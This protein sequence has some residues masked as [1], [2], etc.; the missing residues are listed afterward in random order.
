MNKAE[1]LLNCSITYRNSEKRNDSVP[2]TFDSEYQ[3]KQVMLDILMHEAKESFD[4][5]II[6][7][8]S[9][10][11][12]P[13][14]LQSATPGIY[15]QEKEVI[16]KSAPFP[17]IIYTLS[18]SNTSSSK[19]ETEK[20]VQPT[21][22]VEKKPRKY[23]KSLEEAHVKNN[24][25]TE[26]KLKMEEKRALREIEKEEEKEERKRLLEEETPEQRDQ[27]LNEQREKR[28]QKKQEKLEKE[29][30]ETAPKKE[31]VKKKNEIPED[32]EAACDQVLPPPPKKLSSKTEY[33]ECPI[34]HDRHMYA[35][36]RC[37]INEKMGEVIL[38]G[39]VNEFVKIIQGPPGTGKT[40][41]LLAHLKEKKGRV[42]CC[43]TTNV[44]AAD[45]YNRCVNM[46]LEKE[47]SL[48]LPSD[49]IPKETI[50]MSED[51]N[52]RVVCCTISGRN[53]NL[54]KDQQF[55]N[56]FL[57]EAGQ[58]MEACVWGLFRNEVEYLC[59]AGDIY[60]LPA[61]TSETGKALKHDRSLMQRLI[62]NE[63]PFEELKVQRRM[64]PEISKFPNIFFYEGKLKDMSSKS[65]EK[66]PY[67]FVCVEGEC[68]EDKTSFMNKKEA[69]VC[70]EHA[71]KLE[72]VYENI[73]IICPYTSQCRLLL[74]YQT[75]IPIHTIDS[76]Q[77]KEADCV[78]LSMVRTGN[79]IG[80]WSD[81][82]RLTV[83]LT[84]AK[85][86]LVIVGDVKSWNKT[87]LLDLKTDAIERKLL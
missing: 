69:E 61:Q 3:G 53:G 45:L 58:C 46:G 83:A 50:L 55:E 27:R 73:V 79:S 17:K 11:F 42:L 49:R 76:F 30:D 67:K 82:R 9:L 70:I 22:S 39:E 52:K 86:K 64:H 87:P 12:C 57:D 81:P 71:K 84:R 18:T 63:Y 34:P 23:P 75:G 31:K 21:P 14:D 43:A 4:K 7:P 62:E 47:C 10:V 78:L 68:K 2:N 15:K 1:Y 32:V 25:E 85:Q 33:Y 44:G 29:T 38:N 26:K 8:D 60:Q 54:L 66:E 37:Q 74:S 48:I 41:S 13:V 35:L 80:F 77:G 28:K 65:D 20:Y 16:R 56:V 36:E 24:K 59:M 72:K 6:Q 40:S 51:P 19:K 5:N